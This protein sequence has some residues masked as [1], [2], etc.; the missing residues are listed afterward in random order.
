MFLL[1]NAHRNT[2]SGRYARTELYGA[3]SPV[4]ATSN[5]VARQG[6][7]QVGDGGHD[8]AIAVARRGRHP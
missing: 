2:W 4:S 1:Q 5:C 3:L 7:E 8:G 6:V